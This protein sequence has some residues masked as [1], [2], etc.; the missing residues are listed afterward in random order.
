MQS[1]KFIILLIFLLFIL[2]ISSVDAK[3][4]NTTDS[5]MLSR[6]SNQTEILDSSYVNQSISSSDANSSEAFSSSYSLQNDKPD[7]FVISTGKM[8]SVREFCQ[9]AFKEVGIELKWEGEGVNEK[10]I[11]TATGETIIEVAPE[12]F[13]P[14]EVETLC[15]DSTKAKTELKGIVLHQVS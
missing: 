8:H 5:V 4:L 12:F 2:T 13:R 6:D 3:D 14:A 7:D 9:Y 11:N 1:R 15:G 10:G